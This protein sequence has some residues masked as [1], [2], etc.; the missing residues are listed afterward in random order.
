[1][2]DYAHDAHAVLDAVGWTTCAVVGVSFGGMVAQ[3]FAVTWPST[4]ERLA[5]LCTSAGGRLGSSYPLHTLVDLDP[6]ERAATSLTLMDSRF[7]SDWLAEHPADSALVTDSARRASLP[8][9]DEQLRGEREQLLARAGHDVSD[10]LSVISAPVLVACGKFD[11]IAPPANS[12]AIASEIPNARVKTYEGGH[13]FMVQDRTALPDV[14]N[15]LA[16]S[17]VS[18]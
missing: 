10:R 16:G 9:S 3:E 5:L 4:V 15:F 7:T 13:M 11:G 2:A 14:F 12:E 17:D 6:T 18:E 8:K 1:M